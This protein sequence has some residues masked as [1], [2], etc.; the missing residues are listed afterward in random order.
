MIFNKIDK[1]DMQ[2]VDRGKYEKLYGLLYYNI[3]EEG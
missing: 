2:N 1:P 3:A